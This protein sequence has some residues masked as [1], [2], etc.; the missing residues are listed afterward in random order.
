MVSGLSAE[1]VDFGLT[2][3]LYIIIVLKFME[4][5]AKVKLQL[6]FH[7]SRHSSCV[8]ELGKEAISLRL[9]PFYVYV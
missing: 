4:P 2:K 7:Q 5:E 3:I 6:N 1:T 8:I 9:F